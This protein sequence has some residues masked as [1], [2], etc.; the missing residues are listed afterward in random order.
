VQ[1]GSTFKEAGTTA[2][3]A[4]LLTELT[5]GTTYEIQV[6]ALNSIGYSDP[7]DLFT[8][9][10]AI[11]PDPPSSPETVNSGTDIV[12]MW[13]VPNSNGSPIISYQILFQQQDGEFSEELTYCD[14]SDTAVVTS[15]SCTIPQSVFAE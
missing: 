1:G 2:S 13:T 6:S 9:L 15:R 12:V 3:K 5:L 7:S 8:V 11:R 4:F 14:G 10:H